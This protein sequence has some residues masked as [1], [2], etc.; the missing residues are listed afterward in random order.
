[1]ITEKACACA[2]QQSNAN[3]LDLEDMTLREI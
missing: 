1:M 2:A 3:A